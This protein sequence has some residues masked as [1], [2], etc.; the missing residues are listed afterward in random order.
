MARPKRYSDVR[1]MLLRKLRD[2]PEPTTRELRDELWDILIV[3][4]FMRG[5]SIEHVAAEQPNRNSA[6]SIEAAIRRRMRIPR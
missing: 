2:L 6:Q 3:K 5:N 4:A 1:R